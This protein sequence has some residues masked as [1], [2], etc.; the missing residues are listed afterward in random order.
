MLLEFPHT[1]ESADGLDR[2]PALGIAASEGEEVFVDGQVGVGEVEGDY[3]DQR[4]RS[5]TLSLCGKS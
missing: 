2:N 5:A 1:L 4:T 3:I